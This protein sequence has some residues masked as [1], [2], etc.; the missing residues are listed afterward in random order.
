MRNI[1]LVSETGMDGWWGGTILRRAELSVRQVSRLEGA[2]Q[3]LAR[4]RY[5]L[6][7]LDQ[8][9]A[10]GATLQFLDTVRSRILV[11]SLAGIVI[12]R[13]QDPRLEAAPV[14]TV[15]HPPL[16]PESFNRTV[17]ET[18][19]L[20]PRSSKR[21]LVHLRLA[22]AGPTGAPVGMATT[23]S[24]ND[25]GMMIQSLKPLP[26]NKRF[27][28]TFTGAR[29]LRGLAMPGT[30]IRDDSTP[31]NPAFKRYIV[32]FDEEAG[33][34]RQALARFLEDHY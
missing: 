2:F 15:L 21:Y 3:E 17:A 7:I 34:K 11:D 28:W 22:A 14:R 5:D 1:L 18:L 13:T 29:D 9:H 27:M 33:A 32:R 12:T 4:N 20:P 19:R 31:E 10:E 16:S 30:I 8:A 23:L 24:V 26:M 6:F 25:G